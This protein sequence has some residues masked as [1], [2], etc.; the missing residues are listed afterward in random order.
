MSFL[1]PAFLVGGL[2]VAIPLVLHLLRRDVVQEVPFTAVRL[3]RVS[4]LQ[5]TRRRRLRDPLLLAARI[6]AVLVLA[7]AFARPYV[8]GSAAERALHIVAIDRSFSMGAAGRFDQGLTRARDVIDGVPRGDR[9]AVVAFDDRAEVVAEAG[10]AAEA[11]AALDGLQPGYGSTRYAPL[12]A[13]A[14]ELAGRDA[15]WL[16]VVGDL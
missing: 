16:H 11:R 4:P 7:A 15:A 5:Q 12:V 3:L 10:S 8:A 6:A 13:R 14:I 1:Y 9:V 2:A